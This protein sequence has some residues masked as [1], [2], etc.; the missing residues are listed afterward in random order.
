[1]GRTRA[2]PTPTSRARGVARRSW[3]AT[4]AATGALRTD[5]TGASAVK[6]RH[7]SL[8]AS[9]RISPLERATL[10]ERLARC[11]RWQEERQGDG[12]TPIRVDVHPPRWCVE[13]VHARGTW[14][15]IR[16][17]VNV[18]DHPV[19][20]PDGSVLA[21]S[22]YDADTALFLST[23]GLPLDLPE[24]PTRDDTRA[25]AGRLLDVV[26]DFPFEKDHHRSAWLAG[27]LTP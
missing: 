4:V 26:S 12:D 23:D 5:S 1:M 19:V 27:P 16:P 7:L 2:R 17:L 13:A 10:R 9:I 8:P 24:K 21:A 6:T 20:R 11:A 25:A 15:G 3:P 22:G 14:P 18:V